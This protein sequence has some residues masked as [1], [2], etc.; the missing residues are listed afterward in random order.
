VGYA[1]TKYEW[2]RTYTDDDGV[3]PSKVILDVVI[4][5]LL[6]RFA[7]AMANTQ[8]KLSEEEVMKNEEEK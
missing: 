4:L 7:S 5:E 1:R 2:G 8:L 6:H 3:V